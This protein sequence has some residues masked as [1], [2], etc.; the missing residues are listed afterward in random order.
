MSLLFTIGFI[1]LTVNAVFFNGQSKL[2]RYGFLAVLFILFVYITMDPNLT[3]DSSIY[4][5]YYTDPDLAH[6][7]VG[8]IWLMKLGKLLGL[9]FYQFRGLLFVLEMTFILLALHR[10]KIKNVNFFLVLYTILIFFESPIQL[11]NYLM[12]SIVFFAFSFASPV[13]GIL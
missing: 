8:Y 7:E 9:S 1:G 10:F 5:F 12:A 13:P 6:F 2:I 11:R 4:N 3:F